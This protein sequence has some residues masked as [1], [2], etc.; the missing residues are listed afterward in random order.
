[1]QQYS[2]TTGPPAGW[3][4]LCE[5]QRVLFGSVAWQSV[6]ERSFR[7][8]T[9]YV[10]NGVNGLTITVFRVGPF[11]VGYLGFPVGGRIGPSGSRLDF[12]DDLRRSGTPDMPICIRVPASGFDERVECDHPFVSNIESAIVDLQHWDRASVSKKLRRDVRRAAQTGLELVEVADGASSSSLYDI[13]SATVRRQRGSLRYNETYFASLAALCKT[14]P[15]LRLYTAVDGRKLA[16]FAITARHRSTTYYLHGGAADEYRQQSPS[17]LLLDRA[18]SN[19]KADGSDCFNLMASPPGQPA[20]TRY[21]EKWGATART[22]KTYSVPLG[23]AYPLFKLAEGL[24][25]RVC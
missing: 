7:C 3:Q 18:I 21:K 23:P 10:W 16:G 22:L 13:Y 4:A 5:Q 12:I 20:L 6:L 17:D 2:I 14:Q 25:R 11:K 24:Y 19:A 15:A 9:L 1:V 8:R